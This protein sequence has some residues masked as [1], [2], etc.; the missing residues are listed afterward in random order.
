MSVEK[1]DVT[2][3]KLIGRKEVRARL[4]YESKPLT[5]KETVAILA[6]HL[7]TSEENIIP[8]KILCLTGMRAVDVHAHVY[9]SVEDARKFER[10]YILKRCGLIQ[11]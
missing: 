8:V 11:S 10:R 6:G 5:R 9:K 7:K 1:L 4:R 2:E 3:N